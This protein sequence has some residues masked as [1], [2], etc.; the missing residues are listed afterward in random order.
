MSFWN[1][2]FFPHNR[3]EN[4]DINVL[5][6]FQ[7]A[8]RLLIGGEGLGRNYRNSIGRASTPYAFLELGFYGNIGMHVSLMGWPQ[9][10]CGHSRISRMNPCFGGLLGLRGLLPWTQ[11]GWLS[12]FR[13]LGAVWSG[14]RLFFVTVYWVCSPHSGPR[15]CAVYCN[16]TNPFSS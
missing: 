5:P 3:L 1:Q 14:P 7:I 9:I 8:G 16:W 15:W 2:N 13:T 11:E 12:K 4:Y 10:C 6:P